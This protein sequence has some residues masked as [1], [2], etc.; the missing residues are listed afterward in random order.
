MLVPTQTYQHSH[1]IDIGLLADLL[2]YNADVVTIMLQKNAAAGSGFPSAGPP[3][4]S[5][6]RYE[7]WTASPA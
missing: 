6:D 7:A 2:G 1:H 4:V 3:F 5:A